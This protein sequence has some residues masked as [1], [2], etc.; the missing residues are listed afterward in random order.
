MFHPTQCDSA[1]LLHFS[2]NSS[3]S[4]ERQKVNLL[5]HTVIRALEAKSSFTKS[6]FKITKKLC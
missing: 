4:Q 2:V 1:H 6:H 5:S 3:L